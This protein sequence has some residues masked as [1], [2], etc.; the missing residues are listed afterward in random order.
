[1][2][3]VLERDSGEDSVGECRYLITICQQRLHLRGSLNTWEMSNAQLRANTHTCSP[4]HTHTHT[5]T[6][7]HIYIY[8]YIYIQT[9]RVH[10]VLCT[11]VKRHLLTH[12]HT[13]THTHTR[14]V[15]LRIRLLNLLQQRGLLRMALNYICQGSCSEDLEKEEYPFIVITLRS[16]L[17]TKKKTLLLVGY[18][19]FIAY[20]LL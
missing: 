4:T 9:D 6:D 2:L 12:T 19:G 7:I 1:M 20:Q 5:D 17:W 15:G 3:S 16:T 14:S 18:L 8:I 11:R 10:A 13:H